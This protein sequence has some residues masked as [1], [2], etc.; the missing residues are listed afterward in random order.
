[1]QIRTSRHVVDNGYEIAVHEAGAGP[2]VVFIH[3][4]GPGASG[5]SNF[6]L[7]L[8]A[9]AAAGFHVVAPDLIGYGQSSKPTG[10]D[11]TL[12]LF[13]D[14]LLAAVRSAGVSRAHV[15]GNS[16]GGAVALRIALEQREFVDRLVMMAPGGIE[17]RERYF[18]MP[19]IAKM[20]GDFTAPDFDLAGMRALVSNLVYDPSIISDALVAERYA[21]ARTQPKDVLARMRVPDLSPRLGELT[22]PILGFWGVEDGFCPASGASKFLEACADVRFVSFAR[23]GHW[24]MVERAEEFNRMAVVFLSSGLG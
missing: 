12:D 10:L 24:V 7:N 17:T 18:A 20:V 3:G 11:Y 5:V 13:A 1:M 9:F 6:R 15:V 21:V 8:E 4:S 2:S 14:T 23:V 16:L 22:M 19:G